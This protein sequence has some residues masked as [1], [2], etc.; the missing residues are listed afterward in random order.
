[1]AEFHRPSGFLALQITHSWVQYGLFHDPNDCI[2]GGHIYIYYIIL[3]YI[4]MILYG[5]IHARLPGI[6][7]TQ[8]DG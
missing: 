4:Y 8:L 3:Y 2:Y 1:M 6:A 7:T 5:H